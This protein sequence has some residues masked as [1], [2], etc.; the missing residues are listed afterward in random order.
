MARIPLSPPEVNLEALKKYCI[1]YE[2]SQCPVEVSNIPY[3]N[4]QCHPSPGQEGMKDPLAT[5]TGVFPRGRR[6]E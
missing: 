1:L 2:N 6:K 5:I 3:Q 4:F